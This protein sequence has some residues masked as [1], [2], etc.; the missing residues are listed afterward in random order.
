P[1]AASPSPARR[2]SDLG[3]WLALRPVGR[4]RVGVIDRAET[5]TEEAANAFLKTLEEPPSRSVII[6]IAPGPDALLATVAS[7]CTVVRLKPDR[8]STRLDSSHVKT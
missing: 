1:R 6:L 8:K 5:L 2:S 7:R 3:P 4:W